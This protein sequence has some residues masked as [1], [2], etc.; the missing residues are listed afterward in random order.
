MPMPIYEYICGGCGRSLELLLSGPKAKPV[1]PHCGSTKLAKQ[2][3]T[4]AAHNGSSTPCDSGKCPGAAPAGGC[5]GG[6]C[7]FK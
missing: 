3:S 6:S 2:F 7:P 1:C 5:G 4:F